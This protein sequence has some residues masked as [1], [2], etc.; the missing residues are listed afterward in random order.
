MTTRSDKAA[1]W[2]PYKA[3]IKQLYLIENKTK[4]EV[5]AF[6]KT[7]RDFHKS[8][9]QYQRQFE[10]W[11]F[12]K[13]SKAQE[14]EYMGY[15]I[16]KRKFANKDT[17]ID[18]RGKRLKSRELDK[19]LRRHLPKDFASR[20]LTEYG[21]PTPEGIQVLT[22]PARTDEYH[23]ELNSLPFFQFSQFLRHT[24][25]SRGPSL[26]CHLDFMTIAPAAMDISRGNNDS[27][28]SV[29]EAVMIGQTAEELRSSS[30]AIIRGPP[31]DAIF[32]TISYCAYL[33]SNILLPDENLDRIVRCLVANDQNL[34]LFNFLKPDCPTVSIFMRQ[35]LSSAAR[36][37]HSQ[38][39][40]FLLRLCLASDDPG[41]VFRSSELAREAF[42]CDE[43]ELLAHVLDAG[44]RV[45]EFLGENDFYDVRPDS[46]IVKLLLTKGGLA[47]DINS[48]MYKTVLQSA[49]EYYITETVKLLVDSRGNDIEV[50]DGDFFHSLALGGEG[51]QLLVCSALNVNI[52]FDLG[53]EIDLEFICPETCTFLYPVQSPLE[54]AALHENWDLVKCLVDNNAKIDPDY[55][56]DIDRYVKWISELEDDWHDSTFLPVS[57]ALQAAVLHGN[58]DM[59]TFLLQKGAKVD[60]RPGGG[61]RGYTPLQ[62]A[63]A[64]G[65]KDLVNLLLDWEADVNAPAGDYI[66]STALQVAARS[67]DTGIFEVLLARGANLHQQISRA[68]M[69]ALQNACTAGNIEL[70]QLILNHRCVDVNEPP[71]G[72]GGRTALQ[73][74]SASCAS[75]SLDIMKLL[76]ANGADCNAPPTRK[77]GITAL[78]GAASQGNVAKAK[79]LL[80]RGSQIEVCS[81]QY[82]TTALHLAIENGHFQMVDFLL[83]EG[84]TPYYGASTTTKRNPL[85]E[86]CWNG[87]TRIASLL[88]SRVSGSLYVDIPAA[89]ED[90]VTALQAAVQSGNLELITLL[91]DSGANPNAPGAMVNGQTALERA[92]LASNFKATR[93]LL[94]RGGQFNPDCNILPPCFSHYGHYSQHGC[95]YADRMGF[96][97]LVT[98][99]E[100]DIST[101][102][103]IL[104]DSVLSFA[105]RAGELDLIDLIL[106]SGAL[107]TRRAKTGNPPG[108]EE[109]AQIDSIESITLLIEHGVGVNE[110]ISDEY[111]S[112]TALWI[113]V[114]HGHVKTVKFLLEHGADV[115]ASSQHKTLEY[116]FK[117]GA[118]AE[119]STDIKT[120]LQ[121]AA[122]IGNIEIVMYLVEL[123]CADVNGPARGRFGRT[124]LQNAVE[125]RHVEVT[126]Y[127]LER[128]ADVNAPPAPFGGVTALQAAAISGAAG[129][130]LIL[131]EAK[132]DVTAPGAPEEGRTAIEGAA[133]HGRL[134][135]LHMLLQIHPPGQS[136]A[137]Q[138]KRAEKLAQDKDHYEI[139]RIIRDHRESRGWLDS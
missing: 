103:P 41:S 123:G 124:A 60:G 135:I 125:Y 67:Q 88:L 20:P 118:D 14:Y 43:V 18:I 89:F 120:V 92:I 25:L 19:E 87:D 102:P 33:S 55:H 39:M 3:E 127:L 10:K 44:V 128:G 121:A 24:I 72:E 75:S 105:I 31:T 2:E 70:V 126:R 112:K 132:A 116:L 111:N 90:G 117:D 85:Q 137:D 119:T 79:L 115:E 26:S 48:A 130:V 13:Y 37:R 52:V 94:R 99:G 29:S 91:L 17:E 81:D 69:T 110:P 64:T 73:A 109:A 46:E 106:S 122:E 21:P 23:I 133:E 61:C 51:A 9:T 53:N 42:M 86:A 5:I 138:L 93:I 80:D 1:E 83:R 108:L 49:V 8:P 104:L 76:L 114:S 59:T 68:G 78:Q 11:G 40:R 32:Y 95:R 101:F 28:F 65:N 139:S 47:D 15:A 27:P 66:G 56:V 100:F 35:L 12:V 84:A 34:P 97:S 131:L 50:D 7:G 74:A 38:L 4:A 113:A 62:L 107:L 57:S 96:I 6:M 22:P 134:D 136:L 54:V 82:G 45:E 129:I 16:K 71:S 58:A 36:L 30:E 63:V 77:R 98:G